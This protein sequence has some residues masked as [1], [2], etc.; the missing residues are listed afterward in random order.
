MNVTRFVSIHTQPLYSPLGFCL[1]LPGWAA[2]ER[3][4]KPSCC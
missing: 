1:G 4:K 2:P 3:Y